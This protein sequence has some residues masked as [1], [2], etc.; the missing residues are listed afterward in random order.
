MHKL[1]KLFFRLVALPIRC[2]TVFNFSLVEIP[3][4]FYAQKK[5]TDQVDVQAPYKL[6]CFF[7]GSVVAPLYCK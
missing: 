7:R 6:K 4:F 1:I 3:G 2:Y 5:N